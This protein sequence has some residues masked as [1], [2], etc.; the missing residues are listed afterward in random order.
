[1]WEREREEGPCVLY[2][3][4]LA[5][6]ACTRTA[7]SR[8]TE[9]IPLGSYTIRCSSPSSVIPSLLV[10]QPL[11][12]PTKRPHTT[13]NTTSPASKGASASAPTSPGDHQHETPHLWDDEKRYAVLSRR[14]ETVAAAEA[15]RAAKARALQER[16]HDALTARSQH[17]KD[18]KEVARQRMVAR[19]EAMHAKLEERMARVESNVN[20]KAEAEAAKAA[21][22]SSRHAELTK[23]A[24]ATKERLLAEREAHMKLSA[25]ASLDRL[26]EDQAA[27]RRQRMD[28]S[29]ERARLMALSLHEKEGAEADRLAKARGMV[30][31]TLRKCDA[32]ESRAKQNERLQQAKMRKAVHTRGMMYEIEFK[33]NS[34]QRPESEIGRM[35]GQVDMEEERQ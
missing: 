16:M 32:L 5:V 21:E 27:R 8:G 19:R 29:I 34:L 20:A 2:L 30:E 13:S 14:A 31:E 15:H 3:G 11:P 33:A 26:L 4:G 12:S 23:Q 24:N 10:L 28:A 22:R 1:M 18:L 6:L 7:S 9:T 17:A 35:L 25:S